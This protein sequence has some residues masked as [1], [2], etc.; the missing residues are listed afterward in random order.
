MK[1]RLTLSIMSL[2]TA[3]NIILKPTR[4]L[5]IKN[6]W[7]GVGFENGK[8]LIVGRNSSGYSNILKGI[9]LLLGE[10]FPTYANLSDI[11]FYTYEKLTLRQEK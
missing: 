10:K 3:L 6:Y 7:V 2:S 9:G 8:N 11:D 1:L 4:R 5:I